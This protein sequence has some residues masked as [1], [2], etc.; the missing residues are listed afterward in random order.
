MEQLSRWYRAALGPSWSGVG[1]D[2]LRAAVGGRVVLVTGA[3]S[4]IGEQVAEL[5]G[6][7]GA[8]VLLTARRPELLA[9]TAERIA[10]HGGRATPYVADLADL[11]AVDELA[12]SVLADHERVDVVVSNAGKSIRRSLADTVDR[13]HD[14]TRSNA[15]NFLGPVRLLS[16]LLPSMRTRRSGQLVNV[17]SLSVDLPAANWAA[18]SA[19]KSAFEAWL[20]CVAPELRSD[21]IATTSIHFPLVHTAMSAPTYSTRLPGLTA[22]QA[23]EVVA[24]TL[25]TRPRLL[26]PWWVRL[27][28]VVA[29]NAQGPYEAGSAAVSRWRR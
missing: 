19:T 11:E 28:G 13:F 7:A 6:A 26:V 25:V 20:R 23:A 1:L 18:Y 14:L 4:G 27:A 15:V 12:H 3:S 24:R 8:T 9:A 17:S 10:A 22:R 29:S 16:A 2:R 21:G 5:L